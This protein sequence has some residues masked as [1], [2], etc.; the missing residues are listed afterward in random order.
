VTAL[1]KILDGP[2]NP[3]TGELIFPGYMP[4]AADAPGNWSVWITGAPPGGAWQFFF[5]NRFFSNMVFEDPNWDFRTFDFARD[6]ELTDQKVASIL[7]STN[8]DLRRLR[9]R[10]AKIIMYHGW[11]DGAI[12][13]VNT[14]NYY[15][16]VVRAVAEDNGRRREHPDG[17]HALRETQKFFRL[18]M[19]PGMLHCGGG[20]GPNAFGGVFGASPPR[21]DA[22]HDVLSALDRW[23]DDDVAPDRI[24]ATK[25]VNDDPANGIAMQRPLCPYPQRAV[26]TGR[27]STKDAASFACRV[28]TDHDGDD[29][30]R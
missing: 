27:G 30:D 4:G 15:E 3:R 10:G 18:F 14:V 9:A 6:V 16:T 12:A 25:Y 24:I 1:E 5:G 2:R 28:V 21:V 22:E 8:P 23:V 17:G 7:N 20:P 26:H 11:E 19:A 29:R 13:P